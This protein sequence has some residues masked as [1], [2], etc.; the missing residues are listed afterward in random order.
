MEDPITA[1][2]RIREQAE[3]VK[4]EVDKYVGTNRAEDWFG[5]DSEAVAYLTKMAGFSTYGMR[6]QEVLN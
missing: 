3:K 2:R 5:R 4:A 6:K 1:E